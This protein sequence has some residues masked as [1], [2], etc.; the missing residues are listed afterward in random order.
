L[1]DLKNGSDIKITNKGYTSHLNTKEYKKN[2]A[3]RRIESL[4]NYFKEYEDGV[5]AGYLN[6]KD[7]SNGRL[8]IFEEPIGKEQASNLVSDNPQ[9]KRNSVYSR[10][11]AL[12]R[13]IQVLYYESIEN[14]VKKASLKSMSAPTEQMLTTIKLSEEFF[15]FGD[16]RSGSRP[17][18]DFIIYNTGEIALRI[19]A[20][21]TSCGCTIVD[22]PKQEIPAGSKA[23][24]SVSFNTSHKSGNQTENI[25]I[26]ANIPHGELP[27]I[28]RANVT[29]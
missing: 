18:H 11:A 26:K 1:E 23:V 24:I 15:D 22:W 28:I 5:I 10:A 6:T 29:P 12:E 21:E 20:I 4:V 17:S 9:D 2:L 16:I 3:Q 27:I 25:S 13:R 19:F 7:S 14:K 8:V